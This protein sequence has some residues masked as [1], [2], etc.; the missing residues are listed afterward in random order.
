MGDVQQFREERD[1]ALASYAQALTLFEQVGDKLGEAN[2]RKAKGGREPCREE[3]DAAVASYAQALK[4]FEQVGDK[5]G[6]AKERKA[7]M[8]GEQVREELEEGE[9]RWR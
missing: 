3:V 2:V 6:E 1:A 9:D 8:G 5:L 4:L 7:K